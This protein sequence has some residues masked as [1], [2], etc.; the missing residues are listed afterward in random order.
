MFRRKRG[1]RGTWR[2]LSV[3]A[4]LVVVGESMAGRVGRET[5]MM[6]AGEA[7]FVRRSGKTGAVGEDWGDL[8][9][10]KPEMG[11]LP[12]RSSDMNGRR[13]GLSRES[14]GGLWVATRAVAV[15]KDWRTDE[16]VRDR[17]C[18]YLRG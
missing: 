11:V 6:G 10:A 8:R 12:M 16:W 17:G 7:D 18:G 9:R 14:A 5:G 13:R 3:G 1:T 4:K 2:S 15:E